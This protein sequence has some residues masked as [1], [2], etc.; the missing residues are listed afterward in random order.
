[1]LNNTNQVPRAQDT[2]EQQKLSALQLQAAQWQE[3]QKQWQQYQ[4]NWMSY[5]A[6]YGNQPQGSTQQ[7]STGMYIYLKNV[8]SLL[9]N[10]RV[11]H[12]HYCSA[13]CYYKYNT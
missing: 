9:A 11:C 5:Q 1:M 8:A 10:D 4:Q 3:Q 6:H 13:H 12:C 7:Q 2:A